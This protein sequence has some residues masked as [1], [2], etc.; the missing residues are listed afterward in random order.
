MGAVNNAISIENRTIIEAQ[1]AEY[2][3]SLQRDELRSVAEALRREAEEA[4]AIRREEERLAVEIFNSS[5]IE[6]R[7]V[8]EEANPLP[9]PNEPQVAIRI[10]SKNA[11]ISRSFRA[12]TLVSQLFEYAIVADWDVAPVNEFDLRTSFPVRGLLELQ[13]QTLEEADLFPSAVLLVLEGD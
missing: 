1:D 13:N 5:R 12:S 10:R 6:R 8:F 11:S 2:E 9:E 3:E 7:V 4:E